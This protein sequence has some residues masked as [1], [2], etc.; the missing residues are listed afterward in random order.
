[1]DPEKPASTSPDEEIAR[2]DF[3]KGAGMALGGGAA[4]TTTSSSETL[5]ALPKVAPRPKKK[6]VDGGC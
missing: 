1:M 4:V 6:R 2:Y 5:P 3:R